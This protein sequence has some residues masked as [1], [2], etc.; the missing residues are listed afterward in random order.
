MGGISVSDI[1]TDSST[2]FFRPYETKARLF[3]FRVASELSRLRLPP[4]THLL[5]AAYARRWTAYDTIVVSP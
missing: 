1:A 2:L 3:E 4:G 5:R